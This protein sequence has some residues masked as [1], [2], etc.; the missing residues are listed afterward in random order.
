MYSRG[1]SLFVA[2]NQNSTA[3][4]LNRFQ[5]WRDATQEAS[6]TFYV[7]ADY[8][9]ER[10]QSSGG[11]NRSGKQRTRLASTGAKS[12][13]QN[14]ISTAFAF[15]CTCATFTNLATSSRPRIRT[16]PRTVDLFFLPVSFGLH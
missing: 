4:V 7:P 2:F 6:C 3:A 16:F 8:L 1:F 10:P 14:L 5:N 11:M 15:L 9:T 12:S 13:E